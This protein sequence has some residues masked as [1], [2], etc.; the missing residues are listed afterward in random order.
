[1]VI[2]GLVVL[3]SLGLFSEGPLSSATVR[4]AAG[5]LEIRYERLA[6]NGSPIRMEVRVSA[7]APGDTV[8]RVGPSFADS[9]S[10]RTMQPQPIEQRSG[11]DGTEM[12]FRSTSGTPFRIHFDLLPRRSGIAKS[13]I[14]VAGTSPARFNQFVFP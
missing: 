6:R 3:A 4:D 11:A 5:R 8:I 13:E 7:G 10:I 9:F 12:V 14:A 1:M 2:G